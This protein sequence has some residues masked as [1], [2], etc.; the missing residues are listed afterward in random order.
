[1]DMK[2]KLTKNKSNQFNS[3]NNNFKS[4]DIINPR[5]RIIKLE[6]KKQKNNLYLSEETNTINNSNTIKTNKSNINIKFPN[7]NN[8]IYSPINNSKSFE[9]YYS[10]M[11]V[12]SSSINTKSTKKINNEYL[13]YINL[14]SLFISPIKS[15]KNK[16]S[17]K[18]NFSN[19]IS[20][21]DKKK[22]LFE[23]RIKN[24]KNNFSKN[25]NSNQIISI[26]KTNNSKKKD[27]FFAI[28]NFMKMKY[29]EDVNKILRKKLK[30]NSFFDLKDRD[31]LIKIGQFQI[32]WKNVMDICSSS[33]LASRLKNNNEEMKNISG[34]NK[35]KIKLKKF[36]S[37]RIYTS[38]YRAK[39]L[40][41][42]NNS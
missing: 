22:I 27:S 12:N 26:N 6:Q 1:M 4:L 16:N 40:H 13:D 3:F 19:S 38:L 20:E 31:K 34:E 7:I 35:A 24:L 2:I 39:M 42:K 15:N 10:F 30:Y 33:L 5:R 18:F 9:D 28:K 8:N 11:N 32:F 25:I 29:Y 14:N 17:L 21:K 37:N 23:K 36:P 41:Y